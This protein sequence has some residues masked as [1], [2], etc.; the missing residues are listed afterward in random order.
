MW[1][2]KSDRRREICVKAHS[3]AM[4]NGEQAQNKINNKYPFPPLPAN[5]NEQRLQVL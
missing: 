2:G 5:A 1:L 4:V 3:G